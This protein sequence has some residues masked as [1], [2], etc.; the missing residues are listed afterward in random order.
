MRWCRFDVHYR[1]LLA[2]QCTWVAGVPP[3][4]DNA[5]QVEKR[6]GNGC[7][8][9]GLAVLRARAHWANSPPG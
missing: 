8:S 5:G 6:M 2:E 7:S 1:R 9:T 4:K 3:P